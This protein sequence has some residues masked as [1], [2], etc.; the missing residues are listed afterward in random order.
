MEKIET[1]WVI[2]QGIE[3]FGGRWAYYPPH[4]YYNPITIDEALNEDPHDLYLM[5]STKSPEDVI[6]F[7]EVAL[8]LKNIAF[9]PEQV[10]RDALAK[11]KEGTWSLI[12]EYGLAEVYI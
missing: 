1:S 4:M 2:H 8:L 9:T 6:N 12:T 3:Q 7:Y 5:E 10:F 11:I